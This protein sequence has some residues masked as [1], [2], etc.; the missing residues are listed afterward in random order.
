MGALGIT[1][2]ISIL[3]GALCGYLASHVG[4]SGDKAFNLFTDDGHWEN[5]DG[6]I[7]Y[8]L[9]EVVKQ[10]ETTAAQAENKVVEMAEEFNKEKSESEDEEAQEAQR[11]KDAKKA[12]RKEKKKK[13]AE[14]EAGNGDS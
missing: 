10:I 11:K 12:A 8:N 13:K 5:E 7:D 2:V 1:L 4:M 14:A 6:G 3:S 9:G